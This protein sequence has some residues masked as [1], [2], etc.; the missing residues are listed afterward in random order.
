MSLSR[1]KHKLAV[2]LLATLLHQS[3]WAQP[4]AT[5]SLLEQGRYWQ[6]QGD[7]RRATQAWEKLLLSDPNQQE[8]L[9]GLGLAAVREKRT[10]DAQATLTRLTQLDANSTWVKRLQQDIAL[11]SGTGSADLE[12][13]RML[14]VSGDI[15][16]A[17]Q[18]Y[19]KALQGREPQGDIALEYYS[20]L[21]YSDKGL[22]RAID[23]LQR[24]QRENPNNA[25]VRLA[26]AKH[27]IRTEDR[28]AEGVR[29][30]AQL[31]QRKDV[32]A[33]ATDSWRSGLIWIGAP[34]ADEKA[35]FEAYLK[36]H[37]D[38]AEVRAVMNNPAAPRGAPAVAWRQDAR[39]ARGFAALKNNDLATA[40]AAFQEKLRA[41]PN[42]PDALG[43]LG[44]VRMQQDKP[45][46]AQQLLA[47]AAGR[48]GA[49]RN[50]TRALAGARYWT[51][52]DQAEAARLRGD[53]DGARRLL[54]QAIRLDGANVG[55]YNAMGRVYASAGDMANAEKTYRYVLARQ[56]NDPEAMRGL[57]G[58]LAQTNRPEEALR[59]ISSMTPAQAAEIGDV[60]RLRAS[61]AASR[62]RTAQQRG[63]MAGA[64]QL[65]EDARNTDPSNPW[66]TYELARL[67]LRNGDSARAQ[68]LMDDMVKAQP[69]APDVLYASALLSSERGE[70]GK[71]YDTMTRIPAT[72][73][74]PEMTPFQ[75]RLWVHEQAAQAARRAQ[76]G[77]TTQARSQLAGLE[78]AAAGE[79]DLLGAIAQAYVDA[80]DTPRALA[81]MQPLVN[82]TR[83]AGP[84]VLIPY[85]SV[86]IKAG[87][88][89]QTASVLRQ[90]QK[91][92]M[93]ADQHRQFQDLVSLYTIRQAEAMRQRGDLVAAYDILQPVLQRNPDDPLA[94]G[95]LARM[96]AA[97]GDRDKALDIYRKLQA[98]D[99]DNAQLQIA[100]AGI[101]AEADDWS[102]AQQALNKAVALAPRDPDVLAGAAR[103]YR[104]RGRTGKAA[105][106][107]Q[108]AIAAQEQRNG[109]MALAA[110]SQPAMGN[111]NPDGNPFVGLPGQRS[112]PTRM[113]QVIGEALGEQQPSQP[114]YAY[115]TSEAQYA[116][117]TEA[118]Y[119]IAAAQPQQPAGAYPTDARGDNAVAAN[120][121]AAAYAGGIATRPGPGTGATQTYSPAYYYAQADQAQ[122][123]VPGT[124][125]RANTPDTSPGTLRQELDE[126]MQE[127]SPE[128]RAGAFVR[129][130]NGESGLSKLTEVDA[131]VEALI[132]AGDGKVSLRATPVWLNAGGIDSNSVNR[133]GGGA[134]TGSPGR[135]RDNGVGVSAGYQMQGLSA[136]VGAT[137]LGFEY[138]N[139][140]GGVRI[141][142]PISAS[143]GTWYSVEGSRR[144][145]TDS[146]VSFAGARD[147]RTDQRWGAVTSNGVQGQIGMDNKDYGVY[148]YGSWNKLLGHNVESNTRT[149]AGTG[150]YWNLM[151]E[152]TRQLTAGLNLGTIFYDNNQRYFTYGNGGYF[153]PQQFYALSVPVTWAQ[154][155]G[156]FS[157]KLQGSVGLQHFKEDDAD[158]F[159][160]NGDLQAANGNPKYSGQSHTGVGYNLAAA[161]EYQLNKHLFLGGTLS[162]DNATDYRQYAG[163]LYL[164]YAF[165]PQTRPL[166]LP[167]NPYQSPY[168]R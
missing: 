55:A 94:Q 108:A 166:A 11:A 155:S 33:D 149:E 118:P 157:Y 99:P 168:A 74:T 80:G 26:L 84:D 58:V 40:E 145:V 109:G 81:L 78:A 133:F 37:P 117:S 119:P 134:A 23:G 6:T 152:S 139:V 77:D 110:N 164:R 56:K 100:V 8:A 142:G 120:G 147:D 95:A 116:R 3:G 146:L 29:M 113:S 141:N 75:R 7:N 86:L 97:G 130:N 42:D 54:E 70:W 126:V 138:S 34:R 30:L 18:T 85:A 154:R 27:L 45:A 66:I 89:A 163:G 68:R 4:A 16:K 105:E 47:R 83:P 63:D 38:D 102:G 5:A 111:G 15:D 137:P 25:N 127:R 122:P 167:V 39:L 36:D 2:G 41:T 60:S 62:A 72:G 20:F 112:A 148:A 21:G 65:L 123:T 71:A 160:T 156:N 32:G 115:P 106:L 22:Q 13:A 136:D 61:V 10:G 131:P 103:I 158:Y 87:D 129:S 43:G 24:L 49:G 107:Y 69:E 9:Y 91:Q 135:Q 98:R 114:A 1:H 151:R 128:M 143:D 50:W 79:P 28:R 52:V 124:P 46:E 82:G 150:I 93:D 90:L 44:L 88:D 165:Y 125:V 14:A 57:V 12:Q 96:Y 132:P 121:A 162:M 53:T 59:L 67:L 144:A 92:P 153:S 159:P 101:A 140:V 51:L 35:L 64:R 31:A 76:A 48:P 104:A 161:A 17:M 19:D 73:R